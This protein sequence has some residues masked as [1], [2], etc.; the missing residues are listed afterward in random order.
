MNDHPD[1]LKIQHVLKFSQPA[2]ESAD[3]SPSFD[4]FTADS[5]VWGIWED[6]DYMLCAGLP[7]PPATLRYIASKMAH[8]KVQSASVQGQ[9]VRLTIRPCSSRAALDAL[10][11]DIHE[12]FRYLAGMAKRGY[13]P[14]APKQEPEFV[15][16]SL[17]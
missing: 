10:L 13:K 4:P 9:R 16:P 14:P 2:Q 6:N 17:F 1:A 5:G 8:G 11:D 12:E 15:Q 7:L 3:P